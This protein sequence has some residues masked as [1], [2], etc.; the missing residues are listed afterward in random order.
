MKLRIAFI[1]P[2]F[3]PA[4]ALCIIQ[5]TAHAQGTSGFHVTKTFTIGS[6]GGWD[7]IAVG[8]DQKIYV[9][10]SSDVVILDAKTGDSV[11]FIPNTTGA[12]H[13]IAFAEALGKGFYEQW[14]AEHG[15][16]LR[17]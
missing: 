12:I 6:P 3:L 16:C 17:Y 2:F 4:L 8:P 10:H 11:G 5:Q 9:S 14:P 7:Y 13:G 15:H 1:L